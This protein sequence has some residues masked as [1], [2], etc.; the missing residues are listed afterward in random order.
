[1]VKARIGNSLQLMLV[2]LRL[3]KR[4]ILILFAGTLLAMWTLYYLI[5]VGQMRPFNSTGQ[6][7]ILRIVTV[8]VIMSISATSFVSVVMLFI[9]AV[10]NIKKPR[11]RLISN[12][13]ILIWIVVFL[14]FVTFLFSKLLD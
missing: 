8:V 6:I 7:V 12:R 10:V 11:V 14:F 9:E 4:K 5:V 1:M 2:Y 3:N 13:L